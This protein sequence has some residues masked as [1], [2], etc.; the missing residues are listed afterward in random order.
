MVDFTSGGWRFIFLRG[1][2]RLSVAVDYGGW[3]AAALRLRSKGRLCPTPGSRRSS[4][5]R[6]REVTKRHRR[7]SERKR[8]SVSFVSTIRNLN[9][10]VEQ[11][12]F[13]PH[14]SCI[15]ERAGRERRKASICPCSPCWQLQRVRFSYVPS[16][17]LPRPYIARCLSAGRA[18]PRKL[19]SS[20]Q[21][22]TTCPVKF[23]EAG[24]CLPRELARCLMEHLGAAVHCVV[25]G[26]HSGLGKIQVTRRFS[27]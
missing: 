11:S 18:L 8:S 21:S 14:A 6:L 4:A 16:S 13:R 25:T 3:R 20:W 5:G 24:A 7:G 19:N 15:S 23:A 10:W 9:I 2:C 27:V 12:R 17:H 22:W 1:R 26:V